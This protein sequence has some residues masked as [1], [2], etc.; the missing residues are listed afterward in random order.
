MGF[1]K[2]ARVEHKVINPRHLVDVTI[3]AHVGVRVGTIS[4]GAKLLEGVSNLKSAI[5]DTINHRLM[6]GG[7]RAIENIKVTH[8]AAHTNMGL[9]IG[10]NPKDDRGSNFAKL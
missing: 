9:I 6:V 10:I 3:G 8:P 2:T 7:G 5:A 1:A 4:R